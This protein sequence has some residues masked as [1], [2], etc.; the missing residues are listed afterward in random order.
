MNGVCKG[1]SPWCICLNENTSLNNFFAYN[2]Q[3]KEHYK[4]RSVAFKDSS[5]LSSQMYPVISLLDK[6]H[7]YLFTCA[8][9]RIFTY[10]NNGGGKRQELTQ[11]NGIPPRLRPRPM[12]SKRGETLSRDVI[13]GSLICRYPRDVIRMSVTSLFTLT[14]RT[15]KAGTAGHQQP[16]QPNA[17]RLGDSVTRTHT[18]PQVQTRNLR[19]PALIAAIMTS[20]GVPSK[21][22]A[23]ARLNQMLEPPG[24]L[25]RYSPPGSCRGF[26]PEVTFNKDHV[27]IR[28][29][30]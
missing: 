30:N 20:S 27:L 29:K 16:I 23:S 22:W 4:N 2:R 8:D 21:P 6:L 1:T 14:R 13:I 12:R 15:D 18:R 3:C 25:A 9:K 28:F 11:V 10:K 17:I 19:L 7:M 5:L 26:A 24:S